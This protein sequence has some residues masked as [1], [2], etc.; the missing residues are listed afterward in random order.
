MNFCVPQMSSNQNRSNYLSENFPATKKIQTTCSQCS[1]RLHLKTWLLLDTK[2][3]WNSSQDYALKTSR[4]THF[5]TSVIF[6]GSRNN[7]L[8]VSF[9]L[10]AH[11]VGIKKIN[12]LIKILF[13]K[14]IKI[15]LKPPAHSQIIIAK[16]Y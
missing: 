2:N 7:L 13:M 4:S 15:M 14:E 12:H 5:F 9:D 8:L 1:N 16:Q 10:K 3:D 6:R 11:N